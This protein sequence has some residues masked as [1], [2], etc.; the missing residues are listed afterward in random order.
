MEY[1][2][3]GEEYNHAISGEEDNSQNRDAID[4]LTFAYFMPRFTWIFYR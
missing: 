3:S 1:A 4:I 2:I